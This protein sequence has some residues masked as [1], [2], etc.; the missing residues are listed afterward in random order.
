MFGTGGGSGGY[1]VLAQFLRPGEVADIRVT[2]T[3]TQTFLDVGWQAKNG[4]RAS[5][6]LAL[7]ANSLMNGPQGRGMGEGVLPRQAEFRTLLETERREIEATRQ[8]LLAEANENAQE[9][10]E[11]PG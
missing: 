7:Q 8:R 2:A 9:A 6:Q 3:G 5:T 4:D 1:R 10:P 11:T